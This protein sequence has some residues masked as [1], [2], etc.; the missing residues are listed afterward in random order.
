MANAVKAYIFIECNVGSTKEV[1]EG[2]KRFKGIK[3]LETVTDPM[4]L[5]PFWSLSLYR[6]L[7][8]LSRKMFRK[9]TASPEL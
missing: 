6:K 8:I 7:A 5:S 4:T 3:S 2:L 9:L 1:I